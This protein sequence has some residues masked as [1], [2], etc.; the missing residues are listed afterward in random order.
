MKSKFNDTKPEATITYNWQRYARLTDLQYANLLYITS[1]DDTIILDSN[2]TFKFLDIVNDLKRKHSIRILRNVLLNKGN[3]Y[4]LQKWDKNIKYEQYKLYKLYFNISLDSIQSITQQ[5]S[6][7]AYQFATTGD[8]EASLK[9]L[10]VFIKNYE[11]FES[12]TLMDKQTILHNL[13]LFNGIYTKL[14]NLAYEYIQ[15]NRPSELYLFN[16]F[17]EEDKLLYNCLVNYYGERSI[18]IVTHR[19]HCPFCSVILCFTGNDAEI[20][21]TLEN[22]NVVPIKLCSFDAL[23]FARLSHNV[24]INRCSKSMRLY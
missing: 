10:T 1:G 12:K 5:F 22:G 17:Y 8:N 23:V 4:Q 18:G 9:S 7:V 21:L 14:Y 13:F 3:N 19:D 24:G 16:K 15:R 2:G 20:N 11:I 6:R